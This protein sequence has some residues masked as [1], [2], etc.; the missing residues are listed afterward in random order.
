MAAHRRWRPPGRHRPD[1]NHRPV[2][3]TIITGGF[4]VYPREVEDALATHPAVAASAVYGTPD[5]HWSEAVTATVVL[6]PG[7]QVTPADLTG[8]RPCPQ[9]RTLGPET[10]PARHT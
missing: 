6:R 10:A 8:P 9:G 4:N 3:D 7:Q 2:K 1:H 5:P